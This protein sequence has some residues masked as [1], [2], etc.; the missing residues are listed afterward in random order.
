MTIQKMVSPHREKQD[1]TKGK[2][3]DILLADDD[4]NILESISSCLK[5]DG[6]SI[7]KASDGRAAL[8][9]I[10]KNYFDLIISDLNMPRANGLAVLKEAKIANPDTI[11]IITSGDQ[12]FESVSEAFHLGADS[13]L[14]KPFGPDELYRHINKCFEEL[15]QKKRA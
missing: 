13:Y 12:D 4:L 9:A 7:T 15:E 8:E 3:C 14:V 5:N 6:F 11:V 1:L 10:K 2:W